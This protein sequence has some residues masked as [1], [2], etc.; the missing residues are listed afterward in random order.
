LA[1][2]RGFIDIAVVTNGSN[3]DSS[4]VWESLV[5]FAS[6]IRLSMYDWEANVCGTI[7]SSLRRIESLKQKIGS[8]GSRLQIGVSALTSAQRSERLQQLT[9]QV[10]SSGA[11]WIYF[12]PLCT[13]WGQGRPPPEVQT[14]VIEGINGIKNR[15]E[16]N[17]RI[18]YSKERYEDFPLEFS[19]YHA[20]HFLL[21]VGADGRN[22]LAPEVK[23]HPDFVIADVNGSDN[24]NFLWE[25]SRLDKINS[26]ESQTYSALK[27][28][29]RGVLYNHLIECLDNG[30]K[31]LCS[32]LE[33]ASEKTF[34]FPHVL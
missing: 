24:G 10:F 33:Q 25:G 15:P 17:G 27:S 13:S 30:K 16:F 32:G 14:G 20:A 31:G 7:E 5:E 8:S 23:Y 34:Q 18:F 2:D 4:L 9:E 6:T 12:H 3:L 29:H 21:V 26:Y 1:R 22:Y 11:D 28:R 19:H